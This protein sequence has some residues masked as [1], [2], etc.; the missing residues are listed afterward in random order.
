[1]NLGDNE[2]AYFGDANDL[3]IF[4]NASKSIIEDVGTGNL[5]VRGTN[6]EFLDGTG[7][8]YY[9]TMANNGS[10][11][12][13]WDGNLK[14]STTSTGVD[15]SGTVTATGLTSTNNGVT[16]QSASVTKSALNVANTTNQGINGTA[17]GDQYNWTTGGKM[18]W[19]TNSGTNA[20]LVL[21]ASGN[22]GIGTTSA[23]SKLDVT[24]STASVYTTANTL[25]GDTTAR[26]VNFNT[27]L[28]TC[29]TLLFVSSA[30][31]GSSLATIS[32]VGVAS[33]SMDLTF[34]TRNAGGNT[35]EH[36]RIGSSG[37]VSIGGS[38]TSVFTGAGEDMKF[39]VIGDDSATNIVNN[40]NA[41]I[42][43][44][45]TNQTAGNLAGLHFARADTDDNPNYAGASIV[46]QFPEAQVTGQYPKGLLAFLTSS[47]AN[48]APSEK[49][50][51]DSSG[52]VGIG[53]SSPQGIVHIDQGASDDAHLILETH[54]AGDSKMVF[55][56]GPTAGNWAVGY[57][58]GGGVTENS[59]CFAYKSDGYPSLSGQNKMLLTPAGNLGIGT[60]SPNQKLS[61]AG[62]IESTATSGVA[63][64]ATG[65]GSYNQ[66]NGSSGTAWAYGSVGGNAIPGTAST[67][68]GMHHWNGNSWKNALSI[69]TAG[70]ATMPYQPGFSVRQ[71]AQANIDC[72]S[73][74]Y[75]PFRHI[76]TTNFNTGNHFSSST[77]RFTAPVAGN[78]IFGTTIRY[79]AFSG[80][81]LYVSIVK[82]GS[83]F[84]A[85]ELTSLTGSYLHASVHT[86]MNMAASDYCNV[87]VRCVGDSNI[88]IDNDCNFYGYLLG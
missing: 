45:N 70:R 26:L 30:G 17:A 56:Q 72:S 4:H 88:H 54:S 21:D 55:S 86:I 65:A 20:H 81:Y 19:S 57:D 14:L 69:D 66:Q 74:N 40:S 18:L 60:T 83:L 50:R 6:I 63:F 27:T 68:F 8:E 53:T 43:I 36:M 71:S 32:G 48:H 24:N 77:G 82:N 51:I 29:S 11:G 33:G 16:L 75:I 3:V 41:G 38:E 76:L 5:E 85:R 44:V 52:N 37:F 13:Y 25:T 22:V 35:I 78:Y 9:L 34:A 12:L 84:Y 87:T 23:G 2:K 28:N 59:F 49:M 31:G 47:S 67:T 39:V 10:V 61:V 80:S 64:Y 62:A 58:D 79:D 42:A 7:S 73:S 46:A 1:V 15:V